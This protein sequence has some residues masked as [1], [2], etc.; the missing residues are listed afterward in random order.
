M[1]FNS[2]IDFWT[3]DTAADGAAM[4]APLQ[5]LLEN[6]NFLKTLIFD[7]VCETQA[8]LLASITSATIH[9]ILWKGNSTLIDLVATAGTFKL[10]FCQH[11]DLLG[12]NSTLVAPAGKSITIYGSFACAAPDSGG[13]S[14]TLNSTSTSYIKCKWI[15][16]SGTTGKVVCDAGTVL[17]ERLESGLTLETNGTIGSESYINQEFWDNT[18]NAVE[19]YK[20]KTSDT[21]TVPLFADQ[22][23]LVSGMIQKETLN[24]ET[25]GEQIQLSA[26]VLTDD[27]TCSGSGWGSAP[28]T[29]LNAPIIRQ[30]AVNKTGSDLTKGTPVALY[31]SSGERIKI[32]LLQATSAISEQIIVGI[33]DQDIA[34]NAE[35]K[36]IRNG[37]IIMNTNSWDEG[38]KLYAG[39]TAGVLSNVAPAKGLS[40]I[41]VGIVIK[42]A[43]DS[44]GIVF[45]NPFPV[46]RISQL[47]DV[48]VSGVTDGQA[49]VYEAS[50]G[51]WIKKNISTIINVITAPS[52]TIKFSPIANAGEY[53]K[54]ENIL[55]TITTFIISLGPLP[56][57]TNAYN[58]SIQFSTPETLGITAFN[59]VGP[60]NASVA[61]GN[62]LSSRVLQFSAAQLNHIYATLADQTLVTATSSISYAVATSTLS[63]GS[64]TLVLNGAAT[65]DVYFVCSSTF[66]TVTAV[67]SNEFDIPKLYDNV[68]WL[69]TAPSL[70][71]SK[72][73]EVSVCN[74]LAVIA[75][76]V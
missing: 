69:G 11:Y 29:V 59:V 15:R 28:V 22:K 50:T 41:P 75:G 2:T 6:D 52:E 27:A 40:L 25:F 26:D 17:F 8:E 42:K 9:T 51:L 34:N 16:N 63:V 46:P 64:E 18:N 32:N 19:T 31:G 68:T 4:S 21:D 7:A 39:A 53:T 24:S 72:T 44:D 67:V 14:W 62:I 13:Y 33:L 1:A 12:K 3:K 57:T 74:G 70:E 66:G 38:D 60:G 73:Y 23:I 36:V 47:P 30:T 10:I 65:E 35:G 45:V 5:K 61:V 54:L 76:S 48:S 56:D 58:Y 49:L 43:G 20:V 37:I 71:A 55:S